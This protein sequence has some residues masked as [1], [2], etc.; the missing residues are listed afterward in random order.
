MSGENKD[1]LSLET[2]NPS[3][4][5]LEVCHGYCK[6]QMQVL[7]LLKFELS[8]LNSPK[9]S[10]IRGPLRHLQTE[11]H[12]DPCMDNIE[13]NKTFRRTPTNHFRDSIQLKTS[14]VINVL[15]QTL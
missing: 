11:G 7:K 1:N 8:S 2:T 3:G 4:I 15:I 5:R 10:S 14:L 9:Y 6:G 12:P 13:Q